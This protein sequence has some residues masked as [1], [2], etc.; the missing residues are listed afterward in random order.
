MACGESWDENVPYL[1]RFLDNRRPK[2]TCGLEQL[3][4]AKCMNLHQKVFDQ[5]GP[6]DFL[7][8]LVRIFKN[9]EISHCDTPRGI[10]KQV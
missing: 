10:E 6:S 4:V 1:F 9:R 5:L 8:S 3:H 2:K 7:L